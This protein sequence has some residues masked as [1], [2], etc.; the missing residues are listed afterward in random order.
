MKNEHH[1][2]IVFKKGMRTCII[3]R[4]LFG[5]WCHVYVWKSQQPITNFLVKKERGINRKDQQ[6]WEKEMSQ[7]T[8]WC[9]RESS[10]WSMSFW[11]EGFSQSRMTPLCLFTPKLSSYSN[12]VHIWY[13]LPMWSMLFVW[14]WQLPIIRVGKGCPI[15]F[16]QIRKIILHYIY[17]FIF[18]V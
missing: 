18:N 17:I 11:W 4:N 14:N 1:L 12:W 16:Q 2:L 8:G 13:L 3:F 9:S 15:N 6:W 7:G 10:Q 5:D